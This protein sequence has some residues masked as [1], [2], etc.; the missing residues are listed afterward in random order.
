MPAFLLPVAAGWWGEFYHL[1]SFL[2]WAEIKKNTILHWAELQYSNSHMPK[3]GGFISTLGQM[4]N[5]SSRGPKI[6]NYL[7]S[8]DLYS[9]ICC[10]SAS[11]YAG[12]VCL[13]EDKQLRANSNWWN[14][15]SHLKPD[16]NSTE[17]KYWTVVFQTESP[18]NKENL[19]NHCHFTASWLNW[20]D[21]EGKNLEG[22]RPSC[23]F[24]LL[25]T[26][27]PVSMLACAP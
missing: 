4:L 6:L 19:T 20:K 16:N 8:D 12:N 21:M 25:S 9:L 11:I 14:S 27:K 23:T 24:T 5:S 1:F 18:I 15:D 17:L 10:V 7:H 2:P 22:H 3:E 13:C 26:C